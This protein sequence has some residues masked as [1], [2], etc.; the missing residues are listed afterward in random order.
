MLN[1]CVSFLNDSYGSLA[2]SPKHPQHDILKKAKK[3]GANKHNNANI[4]YTVDTM[5]AIHAAY[6]KHHSSDD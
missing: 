5:R 4:L 1:S 6:V 2:Q 3:A